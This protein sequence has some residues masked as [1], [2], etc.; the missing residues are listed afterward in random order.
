LLE[1]KEAYN[2]QNVL[3]NRSHEIEDESTQVFKPSP[4]LHPAYQARHTRV[5]VWPLWDHNSVKKED[6]V[7]SR[8][9]Q[10]LHPDHYDTSS[11]VLVIPT[12]YIFVILIL[13]I[14]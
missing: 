4:T 2:T 12:A 7:L 9:V 13:L 14:V 5:G 11:G 10:L 8:I 1:L 3:T 6:Y